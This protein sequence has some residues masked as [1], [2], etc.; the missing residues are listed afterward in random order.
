MTVEVYS[1]GK[2]STNGYDAPSNPL[3]KTS[4]YTSDRIYT[5]IYPDNLTTENVVDLCNTANTPE[6][7]LE[8][9]EGYRIKTYDNA[10]KTGLLLDTG[11]ISDADFNTN[12]DY[13]VLIHADDFNLHHFAKITEILTEDVRGDA[14]EFEPR[15]GNEIAEGTKY[16][17]FKGPAK[18]S[19]VQAVSFGILNNSNPELAVSNPFFYFY[20]SDLDKNN[21]LNHNSKYFIRQKDGNSATIDFSTGVSTRTFLT[22]ENYYGEI[23]DYSKYSMKFSLIDNLKD[24]DNPTYYHTSFTGDISTGSPNVANVSIDATTLYVG[25]ELSGIGIGANTRIL[26]ITDANNIVLDANASATTV[27]LT[28]QI[29]PSNEGTT[30]NALMTVADTTDYDDCFPNARRDVD[31]NDSSLSFTGP[32]RYTHYAYS[33]TKNNLA[34]DVIDLNI[35]NAI[36]N[37]GG[38]AEIKLA[39]SYRIQTKKMEEFD[40]LRVR[41]QVFR[42]SFV[43]WI[44]IDAEVDGDSSGANNNVFSFRTTFDLNDY[45][46]VNDEVKIGDYILIVNT[47]NA[48]SGSSQVIDFEDYYRLEGDMT[49]TSG[50]AS[51]SL[52]DKLYRRAYNFTDGT[53]MT[54]FNIIANRN[55]TLFVKLLNE[56]FAFI[57]ATVTNADG[58]KKLLTLSFD[59]DSVV[60][61]S[62]QFAK[63]EYVIE[64]ERINGEIEQLSHYKENGQTFL[65]LK[66]RDRFNKLLSP[67]INKNTLFSQDM[68]YSSRSPYNKI[69]D[70]GVNFAAD[71]NFGTTTFTSSSAYSF[72]QGDEVF[73]KRA[74]GTINFLGIILSNS[75]GTTH[76]LSKKTKTMV[77]S[78]EDIFKR[79]TKAYVLNKA[80]SSNSHVTS[81]TSL[82]GSA[83][84][85]IIFQ[86]GN[87]IDTSKNAAEG[88]LLLGNS[89]S[90]NVN[91]LGYSLKNP[92]NISNDNAFQ[93]E[94]NTF[95][96]D[97]VNTLIDFTILSVNDVEN[98]KKKIIEV[99][100]HIPL[101]LGRIVDN[102]ANVFDSTFTTVWTSAGSQNSN[103][104]NTTATSLLSSESSPRNY[105]NKPLFVN[106]VFVGFLLHAHLDSLGTTTVLTIDRAVSVVSGDVLQTLTYDSTYNTSSKLT[107]ELFLL[108]GGHL[109][110]GKTIGLIHPLK[111]N[112]STYELSYLDYQIYYNGSLSESYGQKFGSKVFRIH[113]LEKGNVNLQFNK[114]RYSATPE[115]VREN[116]YE[117]LSKI[118][119]YAS[120]Y[121]INGGYNFSGSSLVKNIDGIEKSNA[122]HNNPIPQSKGLTSVR[123]SNF[124][125]TLYYSAN[126]SPLLYYLDN[127]LNYRR[128][129][130]LWIKQLDP[131]IS[132]M[133]LFVNGDIIP[134]TSQ[135]T[136]S[137][138]YIDGSN[139]KKTIANYNIL[140]IKSSVESTFTDT[141]TLIKGSSSSLNLKD[142]DY[143][144]SNILSADKDVAD[145]KRFSLMRLTE[146]VYDWAYNQIDPENIPSGKRT[147]LTENI[148]AYTFDALTFTSTS[149]TS[150]NTLTLNGMTS[151]T[152]NLNDIIVD[153]EGRHIGTVSSSTASTITFTSPP[154]KT[155][156]TNFGTSPYYRV[157]KTIEQQPEGHGE[158]DTSFYNS[159]N[160]HMLK[161]IITRDIE[162]LTDTGTEWRTTFGAQITQTNNNTIFS[163]VSF[164]ENITYDLRNNS[165]YYTNSELLNTI[166]RLDVITGSLTNA[167]RLYNE[168][169]LP[170]F[171]DRYTIEDGTNL[172]QKGM[173]GG[174]I[175]A[176]GI[177]EQ[178]SP[179]RWGILSW[180]MVATPF[181]NQTSDSTGTFAYNR[182]SDGIYLGFKPTLTTPSS[183]VD[184][185]SLTSVSGKNTHTYT[186][187]AKEETL[188]LDY[189]D[190]TGC[191]LVLNGGKRYPKN[192]ETSVTTIGNVASLD[193][194]T[195]TDIAYIISHEIDTGKNLSGTSKRYHTITV[196]N[197]LSTSKN[198]RIMQP[199]HTCFYSYSPTTIRVNELS[200]I[201]T[202]IG[203]EAKMY[204]D[205]NSYK[206]INSKG[207]SNEMGENEG[208]LSMYLLID[209][210]GKGSSSDKIYVEDLADLDSIVG[211][212]E[213][214]VCVTDGNEVSKT[215]LKYTKDG[216]DI[217]YFLSFGEMKNM[218]GVVSVSEILTLEIF[219]DITNE[220]KRAIIG[221]GVQVA[222]EGDELIND[223]LET[224]DI[225]YTQTNS[226][227]FD[228]PYYL[229]PNFRSV[230]LFEA[231]N[232][233]LN[234]KNMKLK[235]NGEAFSIISNEDSSNFNNLLIGGSKNIILSTSHS[236]AQTFRNIVEIYEFEKL[237]TAFDFYNE[238]IVYGLRTVSKRKDY[239]SIQKRGRKTL[240]IFDETLAT[241]NDTDKK[242]TELLKLHSSTNIKFRVKVGHKNISQIETGDIVNM[243][244]PAENIPLAQFLVLQIK[245][246]MNGLIELELGRYTKQLEDRFAELLIQ[247]RDN[248]TKL[249]DTQLT[250]SDEEYTFLENLKPQ[251]LRYVVRTRT[252][253]GY[254]TL[255]FSTTLKTHTS[256]LGF[257]SSGSVS[258]ENL[259]DE[260]I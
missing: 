251:I 239:K 240:E 34:Y 258:L 88:S 219:G 192:N 40:K 52:N 30:L 41:H 159:Y 126:E 168:N 124:I 238:I 199:N 163:P 256:A 142:S 3:L 77:T 118:P 257:G 252:S 241:Q 60:S 176:S 110:T 157:L 171:L 231:I 205:I 254:A 220:H 85:G 81:A 128:D 65:E 68:I 190:L 229:A 129:S 173:N 44:E 56:N 248:Q 92:K 183:F 23:K 76:T 29:N 19:N 132:R 99:A 10:S 66:G 169:S 222:Y 123:G 95:T 112:D 203:N 194:V 11:T 102:P 247:S 209:I 155:N 177:A 27:G 87:A 150:G 71:R 161:G 84:K 230:S 75:S 35:E 117:K 178:T 49:F 21:E 255:G 259:V 25:M 89:E 213:K 180:G 63:G 62:L 143:A 235:T 93:C 12:F 253:S 211:E 64:V 144:I 38:Y 45:L 82:V 208:V 4:S 131:K 47:I 260:E 130:E 22:K 212:E 24:L 207:N 8:N 17:I 182:H 152:L 221:T 175:T 51:I 185:D 31:D 57:E 46:N 145:L 103:T 33:P 78:G 106:G 20:N 246:E 79:S 6:S 146:V 149:Y 72:V 48:K 201:Y 197:T 97:I 234:R 70:T 120:S 164:T 245:Y 100:P 74:N 73:V 7:N 179:T 105:H 119:F 16:M 244:I 80:L 147:L 5:F 15:L 133:F 217:G 55:S 135:R 83:S 134:Y 167:D 59:G 210:D 2:T 18:T 237:T 109:H 189:V 187:E 139:N 96:D 69:E 115:N 156:G 184:S 195:P 111:P 42:S 116:Y 26:S 151:P 122:T 54:D 32:T 114:E 104:L 90:S 225:E 233:V 166:L 181:T 236:S 61:N 14:I 101:T 242:A 202:K 196:D 172:I 227:N 141:K 67:V 249:R 153:K 113:N 148:K 224:N 13:F 108:N 154:L 170:V 243:E 43:D 91:S 216:T 158:K 1:I 36:G 9:T 215:S 188:F 250:N 214:I 200:H 162:S 160:L 98:S 223:L 86:G 198:Y 94:I 228:F 206:H 127:N 193:G 174:Y 121:K 136:D 58:D 191:Y 107:H 186:F 138:M 226:A 28:I 232:F 50:Q 37:Q 53:L 125:D 218:L 165:N 140:G 137:L 39:D 204:E